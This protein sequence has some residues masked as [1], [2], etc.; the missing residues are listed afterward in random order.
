[1]FT[2]G[3]FDHWQMKHL[4]LIHNYVPLAQVSNRHH[5]KMI[6]KN[7]MWTD[8]LTKLKGKTSHIYLLFQQKYVLPQQE[9][10][11]LKLPI[12]YKLYCHCI[13]YHTCLVYNIAIHYKSFMINISHTYLFIGKKWTLWVSVQLSEVFS[14]EYTRPPRLPMQITWPWLPVGSFSHGLI[15]VKQKKMWA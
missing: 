5:N 11:Q 14:Y 10:S 4:A 1:M 7:T 15:T 9:M 2:L 13:N 12:Q 8:N 6:R 3:H